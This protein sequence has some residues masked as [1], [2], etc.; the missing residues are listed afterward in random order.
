MKALKKGTVIAA[1]RTDEDFDLALKSK[2]PVIFDLSPDLLTVDYKVRAAHHVGKKLLIHM[3]LATGIGKDRSGILYMKDAGIDGIIST[4][5]SIIKLA[6]E[7]KIFTVQRFFIVDSQSVD[8]TVEAIKTA[9]PDMI[10]V[11]PAIASKTIKKLYEKLDIPIIAGGLIETSE[12]IAVA[13]A[14]GAAAVSTGEETLW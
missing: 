1:V 14:N 3:D 9:K 7:E 5:V 12:E 13:L 2:A 6:R 11:M 10:E 8:T 4:R